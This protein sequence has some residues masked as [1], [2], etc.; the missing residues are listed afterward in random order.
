MCCFLYQ[1][2]VY[3]ISLETAGVHMILNQDGSMQIQICA[4]EIGQG[5]IDTVFSQIAAET[6][7]ITFDKI[8][9]YIYIRY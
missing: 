3:P 6:V 9:Y 1:T 4:T 8:L 2:D 5:A 7:G